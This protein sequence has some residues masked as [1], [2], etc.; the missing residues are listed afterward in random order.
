MA[1]AAAVSNPSVAFVNAYHV[2]EEKVIDVVEA[3]VAKA[4]PLWLPVPDRTFGFHAQ[5]AVE[6]G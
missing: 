3:I 1:T 2:T 5:H 4:A 6:I